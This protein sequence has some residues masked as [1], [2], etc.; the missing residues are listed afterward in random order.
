MMTSCDDARILSME[1]VMELD[2]KT[3]WMMVR[4]Q[5]AT[6]PVIYD[7]ERMPY[8]AFRAINGGR[9]IMYYLR[10]A[11]MRKTW[12]MFDRKPSAALRRETFRKGEQAG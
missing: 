12:V 7:H 5:M 4:G 3:M 6:W 2:K 10:P 11:Q 1:E 9:R 8:L